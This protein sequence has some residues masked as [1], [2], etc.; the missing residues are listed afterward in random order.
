[1]KTEAP[2]RIAIR[3][4]G[5]QVS[6][7]YAEPDTME[8]AVWIGSLSKA[9]MNTVVLEEWIKVLTGAIDTLSGGQLESWEAQPAPEHE[10]GGHS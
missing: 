8:G 5:K 4:E 3:D 7:Y 1:M 2:F 6:A 9:L 10:R